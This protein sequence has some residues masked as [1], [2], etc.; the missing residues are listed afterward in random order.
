MK[1][2]SN[3]K[4]LLNL[5]CFQDRFVPIINFYLMTVGSGKRG[6]GRRGREWLYAGFLLMVRIKY[7]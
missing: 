3:K 5:K 6:E 1:P 2:N 4:I 7:N